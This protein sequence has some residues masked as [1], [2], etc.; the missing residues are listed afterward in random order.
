MDVFKISSDSPFTLAIQE[1]I[2]GFVANTKKIQGEMSSA[3]EAQLRCYEQQGLPHH[4][5]MNALIQ[6][7]KAEISKLSLQEE[8]R[9]E[10]QAHVAAIDNLIQ[11]VNGKAMQ[12]EKWDELQTGVKHIRICKA[13]DRKYKK[14]EV[15]VVPGS[16]CQL[17]W[18]AVFF[19]ISKTDRNFRQMHGTALRGALEREI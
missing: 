7:A 17:A 5:V 3:A 18:N 1:S 6:V 16:H 14:L 10:A 13:F 15:M 8:E 9:A 2:K 19:A 11:V 12:K 4:H